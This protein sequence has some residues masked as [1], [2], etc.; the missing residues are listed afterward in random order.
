MP[1]KERKQQKAFEKSKTTKWEENGGKKQHT[2]PQMDKNRQ[3]DL[4]ENTET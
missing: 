1:M 2:H 4:K 3:A